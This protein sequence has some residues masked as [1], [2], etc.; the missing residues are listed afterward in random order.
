MIK[1]KHVALATTPGVL[2]ASASDVRLLAI[3]KLRCEL[4]VSRSTSQ[5]VLLSMYPDNRSGTFMVIINSYRK[6]IYHFL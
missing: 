6:G 4:R 1:P 3:P 5:H 2:V